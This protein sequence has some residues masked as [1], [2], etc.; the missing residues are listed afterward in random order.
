MNGNG[1]GHARSS[2]PPP[3]KS[4]VSASKEAHV[5]FKTAE[6]IEL[7]GPLGQMMRHAATFEIYT[8][9][10]VLNSSEAL[11]EFSI[12]FH[13]KVIYFGRAVI[14]SLVEA[15]GKVVCEVALD[16]QHW[17]DV[18][19]QAVS[20]S[21]GRIVEEFKK[22]LNEW[23]KSYI[24]TSEFKVA[25]AD[26]QTFLHD[27]QLWLNQIEIN[28]NNQ[29]NPAGWDENS[30]KET[31][32]Q[33]A[34]PIISAIDTLIDRF[35]SIVTGLPKESH[36]TFQAYLRRQLHPYLMASPFAHR[37]FN[38]PLGYAGDYE[39]VDMMI[40]PPEEGTGLFSKLINVWLLS[41]TPA[42]AHR[43]RI[44]HLEQKLVE[45]TLRAKA[46]NRRLQV[47]NLG[48]GPAD[49]IHN[50]AKNC[51]L[52]QL[53][54]FCLVDFNAETLN[55][56]KAKLDSKSTPNR[57]LSYR[58]LKKS[59]S[60]IIKDGGKT[61]CPASG[62]KYG[63]IYCA[64]L[65]DYLPDSV[66]KQLMEVFYQ[67]LAPDGLLLATNASDALNASRPFR[68]SM[69][70]ILDWYLIYRN[71]R[72]FVQV[73]PDGLPEDS[74]GVFADATGANLFLEVRKIKNG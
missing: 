67:M 16:E 5:A 70:Y 28:I 41:Q 26:M 66:C 14:R 54:D 9:K 47:F 11:T 68:Y 33:L 55:V 64:G 39:M 12:N 59:V 43:N 2:T 60:Q 69:E 35:E 51:N 32:A 27:L 4:R 34:K 48:C 37:A 36:P 61:L 19:V 10:T 52:A 46:S 24:V 15:G 71:A 25:I 3:P 18:D 58:T 65:F 29:R 49:E 63:Y 17:L 45:E 56:L 21:S 44:S 31:I 50:F 13:G 62:E 20:E 40:R 22:F 1:T 38:K 72:Q 23:Q 57:P 74:T 6:G 7:R 73:L 8:P 30:E 53:V 42:Q